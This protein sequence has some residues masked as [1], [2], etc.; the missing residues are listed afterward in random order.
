MN[1]SIWSPIRQRTLKKFCSLWNC[2]FLRVK[3]DTVR[4][5]SYLVSAAACHSAKVLKKKKQTKSSFHHLWALTVAINAVSHLR[6]FL[7]WLARRKSYST[8][9]EPWLENAIHIGKRAVS[10]SED[11][12]QL[13]EGPDVSPPIGPAGGKLQPASRRQQKRHY[14]HIKCKLKGC[15]LVRDK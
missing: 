14:A 6:P 1:L 3:K 4:R 8:R 10:A 12:I 5:N 11:G 2:L 15:V 13:P 7:P 9:R